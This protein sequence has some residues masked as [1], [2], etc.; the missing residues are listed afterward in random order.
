MWDKDMIVMGDNH[1]MQQYKIYAQLNHHNSLVAIT[2]DP[3]SCVECDTDLYT[4]Q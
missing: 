4:V 3:E 2:T 1:Y